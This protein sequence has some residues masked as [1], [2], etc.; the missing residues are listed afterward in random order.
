MRKCAGCEKKLTNGSYH[1]E[2]YCYPCYLKLDVALKKN[3]KP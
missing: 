3:R 1:A 2:G